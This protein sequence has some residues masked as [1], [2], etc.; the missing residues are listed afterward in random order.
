MKLVVFDDI[1]NFVV[2]TFFIWS[3]LETQ[4][5]DRLLFSVSRSVQYIN[6]FSLKMTSNE[7]MLN[8][9]VA[10]L[11]ENYKFRIKFISI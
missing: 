5:I 3:Y 7:K 10:D 9:K 1:Y 4:K 11:S 8:Y 6:F 2:Q